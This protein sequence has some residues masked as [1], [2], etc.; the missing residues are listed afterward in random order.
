MGPKLLKIVVAIT[1]FCLPLLAFVTPAQADL[2]SDLVTLVNNLRVG[3]SAAPLATD[4][5]LTSAAQQWA[6]HMA[7]TGVLAHNPNLATQAPS[8][9]TKI[10]ENIGDGFSLTGV[11]NALVAS[12]DHYANMVDRTFNRTGVGVATDSRGQVWVA[13]ELAAYPPPPVP[14]IV[15]PTSGTVIFP[16]PQPF[17]WRQ[18]AGGLYYGLTV[19]TSQGGLDLVNSGLLPAS[20]LSYTVPA[21][22]GG[23]QLWARV[24]T[25]VQ[26]TWTWSDVK[27]SVA[28]LSTATFTQPLN[29]A[30]NV[31]TTQPFTWTPV[32]SAG[33]YWVGVGT[34]QGGYDLVNSGALQP[35]QTSYVVP[36]LPAGRTLWARV[37]SYIGGSWLHYNDVSFTAAP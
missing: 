22:P 30:T 37:Y 32:A 17:S 2:P 21:L 19:G 34:T 3:V 27:F 7:S 9:W 33:L 8:G 15:F 24:Y 31:D 14:S 26:A 29:G 6:N 36:A 35:S 4:P 20:Q 23:Q 13:E 16:S 25:Y 1:A 11:F 18:V 12:P 5:T 10:G 28:G